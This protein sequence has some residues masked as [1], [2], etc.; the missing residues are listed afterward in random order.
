MWQLPLRGGVTPLDTAWRFLKANPYQQMGT[1]MRR[2][3]DSWGGG[4][5]IFSR[6][7]SEGV[8]DVPAF[9]GERSPQPIGSATMH[10][11]IEGLIRRLAGIPTMA[12]Q[13]TQERLM[14]L[15]DERR[16]L[17]D[18]DFPIAVDEAGFDADW[19]APWKDHP[20]RDFL[21][22]PQ[23][24]RGTPPSTVERKE[25]KGP[26]GE[27]LFEDVEPTTRAGWEIFGPDDERFDFDEWRKNL[28][29]WTDSQ[30]AFKDWH[31]RNDLKAW[32]KFKDNVELH[33][34]P[35]PGDFDQWR[36]DTGRFNPNAPVNDPPQLQMA[37]VGQQIPGL[38]I[39]HPPDINMEGINVPY[40]SK[41]LNV[42]ALGQVNPTE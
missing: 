23:R 22:A 27:D 35:D 31:L 26:F 8:D 1:M 21:P 10:P 41:D 15:I 32:R 14:D 38:N 2:H 39:F 11:A 42:G 16:N 20:V 24:V 4:D 34:R 25:G 18:L 5:P 37:Q 30:D 9:R 6:L 40:W 12:P 33:G 28:G 17:H 7:G 29:Q 13:E 3:A 19:D 36:I